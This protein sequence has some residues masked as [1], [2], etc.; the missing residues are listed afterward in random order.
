MKQPQSNHEDFIA[1]FLNP[2]RS[3]YNAS[4]TLALGLKERGHRVVYIGYPW[5]EDLVS[6]LGFEFISFMEKNTYKKLVLT[7]GSRAAW[8]LN[9]LMKEGVE[10]WLETETPA[11]V[12]LDQF[13]WEQAGA[14][15]KRNI[16]IQAI[17]TCLAGFY[18]ASVPPV[19][20]P[21]VPDAATGKANGFN[22]VIAW[23]K[24]RVFH[25]AISKI[26]KKA[27]A[28]FLDDIQKNGVG[29]SWGEYGRRLQIP[30]LVLCP[31][32]FDFPIVAQSF[33]RRIYAGACVANI[34]ADNGKTFDW[35]QI[36][37]AKEIVY[38]SVGSHP[39]LAK[40]RRKLFS[41]AINAL[42]E[43]PRLHFILQASDL[44]DL[45][46]CH[47]LPA[48][49]TVCEWVPQMEV[50][51]RASLFI[52]HGGL[53]SVRESIFHGVP[54]L[55]FPWGVDQPGNAARVEYHNLGQRGN[56]AKVTPAV[57]GRMI[58]D[59]LGNPNY[60]ESIKK[61]QTIFRQQEDCKTG[62][63]LVEQTLS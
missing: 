58:D 5:F 60:T 35:S 53:S 8:Q 33:D 44:E 7:P 31:R 48:N 54:M 50:L 2:E 9:R 49:V 1:I 34:P 40:N 62:I 42:K 43:R 38:C 10:K 15:L 13:I 63:E 28:P 14:F 61:M 21:I 51:S 55:V 16:P 56:A 57:M 37:T 47:P 17:N 46:Q 39:H 23:Q 26:N 30:E 27:M 19:F 18:H 29:L 3:G 24:L 41:A 52:T 22:N 36:D 32:E 45:K 20:S 4:L 6:D 59:I 12:L 25:W 11:L